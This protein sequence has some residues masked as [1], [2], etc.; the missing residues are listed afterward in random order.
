MFL[1]ILQ[2]DPS[3][4]G[5]PRVRGDVPRAPTMGVKS[6]GFSPRARGCSSR[7][8]R[9][10]LRQQVFPACAGMFPTRYTSVIMLTCFPRVRGDVPGTNCMTTSTPSFSPRARGCSLAED[11][12]T[13]QA[14]VFPACAGMF[15]LSGCCHRHWRCFPR[16][17]GDVPVLPAL[18]P[19]A[20]WFSPRARGCSVGVL[21]DHQRFSVFP[22][23]AG[24]FRLL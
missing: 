3:T 16:V 20:W 22:A 4:G 21:V 13:P 17:R 12:L 10:C 2:G 8:V 18:D 23:C 6:S 14:K 9:P 19:A 24:M 7:R 15:R 1:Q 11:T 5:F